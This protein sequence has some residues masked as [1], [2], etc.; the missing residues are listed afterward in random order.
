MSVEYSWDAPDTAVAVIDSTGTSGLS[1]GADLKNLATAA[2]V[3]TPLITPAAP[4]PAYVSYMCKSKLASAT[5]VSGKTFLQAWF[6]H[7][8]DGTN[9]SSETGTVIPSRAPDFIITW[10]QIANAGGYYLVSTPWLILRPP[11]PYEILLLNSV[12]QSTTN[13]NNDN[14]LYEV[15]FNDKGT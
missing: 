11:W 8:T 4:L 6:L 9:V 10:P 7:K 5:S 15:T 2:Y 14:I 13:V 12:G 3:I 1:S